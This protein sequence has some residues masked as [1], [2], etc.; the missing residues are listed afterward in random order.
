MATKSV[1][2][3]ILYV[4]K[5]QRHT[6]TH[7]FEWLESEKLA[8]LTADWQRCKA[9][10]ALLH[11]CYECKANINSV[12]SHVDGNYPQCHVVRMAFCL[13]GSFQNFVTPN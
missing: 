7:V 3:Y 8:I 9:T 10:G 2:S 12:V 5:E 1:K 13:C 11:C 4:Q 6:T